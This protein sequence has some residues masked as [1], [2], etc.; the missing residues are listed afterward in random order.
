MLD[1]ARFTDAEGMFCGDVVFDVERGCPQDCVGVDPMD[2][3]HRKRYGSGLQRQTL[4]QPLVRGGKV[5]EGQDLTDVHAAKARCR[6]QL[7]C[8]DASVKRFYNP[9][10]YPAGLEKGLHAK[11]DAMIRELRG[12]DMY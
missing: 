11:R 3:T 1:T 6:A 5:V 4:L 2:S 10:R 7:A 12:E 8:L 9:H